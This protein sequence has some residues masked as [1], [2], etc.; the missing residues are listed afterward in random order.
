MTIQYDP[1]HISRFYDQYGER[2]W[3]RFDDATA[4]INRVNYH[5]HRTYLERYIASGDRVLEV[6]AGAGRFTIN[7]ARLGA[8]VTVG[9]ISPGQLALNG[10]KV[11]AAGC[12]GSVAAR[13]ALDVVDLSHYPTDSFDA[14]VCYGGPISYVF[15]RADD[16]VGELV[17]V[18]K[19]GGH[20]LLSVMSLIGSTGE[21][22]PGVVEVAREQGV[23][24][25]ERVIATGDVYGNVA[26]GGHYCRMYRWLELQQLLSRQSCTIVAASASNHLSVANEATLQS[27]VADGPL[28]DAFLRWEEELC[29]EP[30]A[31]D[32]GT[33]IIAVVRKSDGV[34]HD[35]VCTALANVVDSR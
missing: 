27:I 13:E 16:A 23:D 20:I 2:E 6:G 4:P 9:D 35:F 30:G 8:T 7:L 32:G 26:A 33:H 14:T 10:E 1:A 31:L 34:G 3:D 15:D 21:L 24:A 28:W 17:R 5:I 18:T 25:I 12:E 29:R 22:L 11:R 19:P